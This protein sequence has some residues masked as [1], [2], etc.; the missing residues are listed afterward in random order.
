[1]KTFKI[2]VSFLELLTLRGAI[3]NAILKES[4]DL[5]STKDYKMMKLEQLTDIYQRIEEIIIEETKRK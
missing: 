2:E 1:M 3:R 4:T 5:T